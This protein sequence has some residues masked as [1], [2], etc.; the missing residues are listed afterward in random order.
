MPRRLKAFGALLVAIAAVPA[1]GQG[2]DRVQAFPVEY[3]AASRPADAFDMV[4]KLPGFELIEGDEEVRGFTGSRGNVLFDG[5]A[6]TSK[7]ETLE[8]ILRRIPASS[9]LRIEL[10]RGGSRGTATGGYDLVAN[11]MRRTLCGT[12]SS[13]LAGTSAANEIGVKP[14]LRFE[15][16][17]QA[18]GRRLEA[19]AALE[20]DIDDDSGRGAIV[21]RTPTGDL[22]EREQRDEREFTRL[23]SLDAEYKLPL[24]RGELVAN[25]NLDGERTLERIRS[26]DGPG[27]SLATDRERSWSGEAGAQYRAETAGGDLEALITQR[28]GRLRA[29]AEEEDE[30]FTEATRT[31]ETIGRVE[32]RRGSER[33]HLFGSIEGALNRLTSDASLIIGGNEVPISGSDVHVSERRT[34]A[35]VG[36]IWKPNG[37]VVLEASMRAELSSIR[38]TGDSPSREHFLFWKPRFRLSWGQSSRRVQSTI[39]REV[40]QLD[41]ED[42]VASAELD[43]DD[44]IAGAAALRPPATWAFSTTFEQ[45]FWNDGALLL[46]WRQEWIDDVLD[47]VVVERDGELFDAVGNI[48]R[49]KRR[50]LKVELT[51]PFERVGLAGMQ[52]KSTLAFIRSRV[53]DPITGR[54]R[55]I[56]E[57]RPFE[58]DVR[59]THDLPGGRWSWGVDASF[60]HREREFR[61]DEERLERKGTSF[62][63]NVEFRPR[64]DWRIRLDAENFG[65]R[66]LVETRKKFESSRTSGILDAIETRR[67]RT[68]PIVTVS[69]RKSFGAAAD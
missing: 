55:V 44:V 28:V 69:V 62:G 61:L 2:D 58:G 31:S 10:I 38:S 7:Q 8:E 39:E 66:S 5:R 29:R 36:G 15:L 60:A 9:V 12:S 34:E 22:I 54:K 13:L 37:T 51:V 21:E 63:A 53:T 23:L 50:I 49:G 3:F 45:R 56:T 11:I 35:A 19:A 16:S 6:P 47:R 27:S 46:T 24:G 59:L 40:A 64:A 4:L 18:G 30:R 52:L 25:T 43:R 67:L 48:G 26:G 20:T 17:R 42:F 32:Y 41:F 14:N 68:S 57:D 65:S 1:A 33:L